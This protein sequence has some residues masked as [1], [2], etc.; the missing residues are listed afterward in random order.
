MSN[1]KNESSSAIA[2]HVLQIENSLKIGTAEISASSE[3]LIASAFLCFNN[4]GVTHLNGVRLSYPDR[5]LLASIITVYV[6]DVDWSCGVVGERLNSPLGRNVQA[7]SGWKYPN[8]LQCGIVISQSNNV[9]QIRADSI[10]NAQQFYISNTENIL[11]NVNDGVGGPGYT[12]ND[13]SFDLFVR[14]DQL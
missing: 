8:A 9:F 6:R 11:V 2:T 5:P 10:E 3:T 13:G 7:A 1:A 12:D 4:I 14:I